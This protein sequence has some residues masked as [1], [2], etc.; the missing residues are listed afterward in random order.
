MISTFPLVSIL[1][2]VYNVEN[3]VERCVRSLQSQT[4]PNI[5]IIVVDDCSSDSSG[6]IVEKLA[7]NDSHITVIH[8]K[9]NMGLSSARNTGLDHAHG[10]FITFVDSDDW[11]EPDYVSY[12]YDLSLRT[13]ADIAVGKNFFTSQYREQIYDDEISIITPED[14]LCDIFYN[15]IHVGVW[16]RLYKTKC[17]G[18]CRFRID[19]K[20]GEGMQFNAQVVPNANYVSVGLRRVYTYNVDNNSS[21]TKKPDVEKQAYGSIVTMEIIKKTLIQCSKRLDDA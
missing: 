8:H 20:T 12:L 7:S 2:A 4:Y 10:Q 15:R 1:L 21:A 11:V 18:N 14:M 3:Y 13:G 16:N 5:E 6:S 9:K 17:I 19:A